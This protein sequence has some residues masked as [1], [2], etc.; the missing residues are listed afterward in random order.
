MI[1]IRSHTVL[2]FR[3]ADIRY[4]FL[5]TPTLQAQVDSEYD[6]WKA[7]DCQYYESMCQT[8][9]AIISGNTVPDIE[10]C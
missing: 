4:P 5:H 3:S 2:D 6:S 8:H 10:Y 9:G 7:E 1:G